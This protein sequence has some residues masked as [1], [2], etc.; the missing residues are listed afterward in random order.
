MRVDLDG[1]LNTAISL[2]VEDGRISRIYA[3]RNPKKLARLEEEL[4][5]SRTH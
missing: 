1:E 3:V 4:R 5:L 2:V